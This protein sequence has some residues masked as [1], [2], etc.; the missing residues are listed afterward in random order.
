MSRVPPSGPPGPCLATPEGSG[1]GTPRQ[2]PPGLHVV[3]VPIGNLADITQRAL[4]V[5]AGVDAVACEDTR[6]TGK[7]LAAHAVRARLI[8]HHEHNAAQ[9]RPELLDRL[10]AGAAIALVA[11]A[12][13]PLIS[14]PGYKLVR[15]A[16]DAG[17][18]VHAVPG[19]TAAVAALSVAGL[20]T[21]RFLFQGFPP[22]KQGARR[23]VLAELASVPA[24]LVFYE[25]P[26]RLTASLA[27]MAAV[28]G[29]EREAAVVRELTKRFEE[30]RRDT[31][32]NLE[33]RQAA[34]PARG[35]VVVVVAPPEPAGPADAETVDARLREA[36]RTQRVRDA[37][38]AV[39]AATGWSRKAVYTR[40]LAL[41]DGG[42]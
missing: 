2:A 15:A 20:P 21:G 5:L 16:Q 41:K 19:P 4:D 25:S 11:D 9:R 7:L 6:V 38:R 37:A 13:T 12:G 34:D 22:A 39:A 27:D 33:T 36:L 30:T 1:G 29:A 24:T 32:S 28:L 42:A 40:A 10:A 3:A 23:E 18:P 14:D 31:L 17:L 35:E 8:S 26:H